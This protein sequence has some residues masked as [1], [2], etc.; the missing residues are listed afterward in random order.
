MSGIAGSYTER[1][2]TRSTIASVVASLVLHAVA[3]AWLSSAWAKSEAGWTRDSADANP[4]D[5]ERSEEDVRLGIESSRRAT[6]TWLGFA[7]PTPHRATESEIEQAAL[8]MAPPG[9]PEPPS[10]PSRV[11]EFQPVQPDAAP[12]DQAEPTEAANSEPAESFERV[13]DLAHAAEAISERAVDEASDPAERILEVS[14]SPTPAPQ[15]PDTD[16]TGTPDEPTAGSAEDVVDPAPRSS[17]EANPAP[18]PAQ[19]TKPMK[20]EPPSSNAPAGE[21]AGADSMPG[22]LSDRESTPTSK[23]IDIDILDWG[24]PAAGEGVRVNP[25]R[26]RIP[27]TVAVSMRMIRASVL[28][29]F[30]GDGRVRKVRWAT[31]TVGR[32]EIQIRTN[33][34]MA[35]NA[36]WNAVHNWTASGERIR[37]LKEAGPDAVLTIRMDIKIRP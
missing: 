20:P 13:D 33:N 14:E 3:L 23:P 8:V 22:L 6:I 15:E 12:T 30:G 2:A 24:R 19:S 7:D 4:S 34:P 1:R 31:R 27:D 28:I 26:P 17:E 16:A 37:A 9:A 36:I 11:A 25:V 18:E 29:D 32:R 35:D 5:P 21:N 10:S